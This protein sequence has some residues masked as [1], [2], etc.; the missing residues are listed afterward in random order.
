MNWFDSHC[1]LKGF[2]TKGILSEVLARAEEKGVSRMTAIGTSSDDWNFYHNLS[3]EYKN[4]IYYSIGLHPSYVKEGFEQELLKMES[5]LNSYDKPVAIGEIGLDYFHLPRDRSKVVRIIQNQKSAFAKQL[6]LATSMNLP[7]VIHSRN[8][9]SD[10]LQLI[11][12]SEMPWDNVLFHCF[13]E[14]LN[15][16]K[17]LNDRGGWASF[18]GMVTYKKNVFLRQALEKQGLNKLIIETDSPYLAPDPKRGSENE[19]SYLF[20]TGEHIASYLNTPLSEIAQKSFENT[21]KFYKIEN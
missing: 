2:Q 7:V 15:E 21:N 9:F 8:A 19:P 5:L 14:G 6:Q 4:R 1:H 10:C 11:E 20:F 17:E 12:E 13:S 18:T 16:I 3:K